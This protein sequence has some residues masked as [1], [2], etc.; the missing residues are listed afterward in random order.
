M[1]DK[2]EFYWRAAIVR[3]LED[4]RCTNVQKNEYGYVVNSSVFVFLKYSTKARTPW[5]FTFSNEEIMR[6]NQISSQYDKIVVGLI[7]GGD[8]VCAVDWF[9]L[10]TLLVDKPGWISARRNFNERYGVTGP[11]G[12]LDRKIPLQ[13]WPLLIFEK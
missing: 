6:L 10:R 9:Q 12:G 7:C 3:L 5:G 4:S 2:Q 11:A 13:S 8:G 1:I